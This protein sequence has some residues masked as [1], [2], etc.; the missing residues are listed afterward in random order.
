MGSITE[1]YSEE[2]SHLDGKMGAG[3]FGLS[4]CIGGKIDFFLKYSLSS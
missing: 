2:E 3:D 1:Q 4:P